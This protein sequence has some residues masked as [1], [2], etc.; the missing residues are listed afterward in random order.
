MTE[1]KLLTYLYFRHK[2]NPPMELQHNK[3][4]N[5][6][7]HNR[8]S[9]RMPGWDYSGPGRYFVTICTGNF[10]EYFGEIVNGKMILSEP[11]KIADKYWME[12][13][14]H[15]PNVEL[16]AF[17][18]MPNH[19]HGIIVITRWLNDFEYSRI[20][21][22]ARDTR[23]ARRDVALPR[24]YNDTT[25]TNANDAN[26]TNDTNNTNGAN[27]NTNNETLTKNQKMTAITPKP[28]SLPVIIGSFKSICTKKFNKFDHEWHG[29][30][31]RFHDHIIR[32]NDELYRIRQYIINNPLKWEMDKNK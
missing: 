2:N 10:S 6:E 17:Q 19:I 25:T 22:D 20:T 29:W 27:A 13:P 26:D 23:N 31:S 16:N 1:I 7:I 3:N 32:D 12:I 21:R 5:P 30:Q 15:F 4:Y 24:P 8:H 18:V 28:G 9:Y 11:G 14:C